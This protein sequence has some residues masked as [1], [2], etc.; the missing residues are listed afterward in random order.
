VETEVSV[1]DDVDGDH[2]NYLAQDKA[3]ESADE[4]ESTQMNWNQ[5]FVLCG[6]MIRS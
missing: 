2:V 3:N 5:R 4:L 6:K 1:K